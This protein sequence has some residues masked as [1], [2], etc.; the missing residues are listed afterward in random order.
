M[1]KLRKLIREEVNR[2]LKEGMPSDFESEIIQN[3]MDN[4]IRAYNW[5]MSIYRNDPFLNK[6]YRTLGTLH[7]DLRKFKLKRDK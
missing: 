4:I 6:S 3:A 5:L 1:N 7:N 2:Q